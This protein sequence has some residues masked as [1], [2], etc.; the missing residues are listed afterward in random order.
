MKA[1]STL[2]G[3]L[4]LFFISAKSIASEVGSFT[5][6]AINKEVTV[7]AYEES[8]N[9]DGGNAVD[10]NT[11]SYWAAQTF[12]QWME[13]D[14]GDTYS[15]SEIELICKSRAYQY[16]VEV[17]TSAG[18]PYT[19]V[20]DRSSN[21]T[22]GTNSDPIKDT[23][24]TTEARYVKLTITN[25][26]NYSGDW[27]SVEEFRIYGYDGI[28]GSTGSDTNTGVTPEPGNASIP[29]DLMRNCEQWKITYPDGEEVKKL[30]SEKN[31]E[32]FYVNDDKNAIVFYAPIRSNNGTTPNSD[33]IRSELRE[34]TEDGNNDVE[35]TTSGSHMLYVKQAIT[36]LPIVKPKLVAS[37]IHGDKEAG[38]DDAMVLRLEGSHLFL[39]F[40]GNNLRSNLTIK[41]D[42]T[43]GT[44]HEV[45]FLVIDGKHYCY[46]SEDGNLASAFANKTASKYL[47]KDGNNS[48]VMDIDYDQ[49]YFKVGNYTQSNATKE[50]DYTDDPNNYGE[51]VVYDFNVEHNKYFSI[52]DDEN[53]IPVSINSEVANESANADIYIYPNP[54][55]DIINLDFANIDDVTKLEIYTLAGNLVFTHNINSSKTTINISQLTKGM[56]LIK[57]NGE[58]PI[59]KQFIKK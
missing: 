18:G 43:L 38:I 11:S 50:G 20:A 17:S 8:K 23:F 19:T 25:A 48:Y 47:V 59:V 15:I 6:L 13:V 30:C 14:L 42:Y 7:S 57:T 54:S 35:W 9:N 26:Y 29:A 21:T 39:S 49:A 36:H 12:P 16:T 33:N 22:I 1:Q 53:A 32:Y 56:Y 34:R 31:N 52:E 37:Q 5:N 4:L 55:D 44:I 58:N 28:E 2:L 27:I 46:Y 3:I 40:N 45:I 10:G 41:T 24:S 51:V